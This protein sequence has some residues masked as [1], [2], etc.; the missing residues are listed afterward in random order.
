MFIVREVFGYSIKRLNE[1]LKSICEKLSEDDR[2]E[3]EKAMGCEIDS[4][5]SNSAVEICA[6]AG[7]PR[8]RI[9]GIVGFFFGNL[10]K[11]NMEFRLVGKQRLASF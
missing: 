6:S 9:L 3:F 4:L 10:F 5:T 11:M 7:V 1:R 8:D 2:K